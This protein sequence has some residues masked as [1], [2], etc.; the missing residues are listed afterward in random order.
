M[1][2]IEAPSEYIGT[3]PIHF[4]AG[5]ITGC[6][7]WQSFMVKRLQGLDICVVNPRRANFPMDDMVEGE[8]QIKWEAR[9]LERANTISF[10]FPEETLCPITLFELGSWSVTDKTIFVGCSSEYKRRFDVQV[11]MRLRRPG[12]KVVSS[13][14]MLSQQIRLHYRFL[15]QN[16][17]A[18]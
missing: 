7:D 4:L 11:Q 15:N 18:S 14:Y 3:K 9:Y 16:E 6:P 5:G 8:K 12:L 1:I 10:W 13:P 17:E 2:Y